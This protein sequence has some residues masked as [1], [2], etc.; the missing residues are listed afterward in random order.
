MVV[1]CT[2]GCLAG[3][4]WIS[5]ELDDEAKRCLPICLAFPPLAADPRLQG[6]R[7]TKAHPCLS[8]GPSFWL[9]SSEYGRIGR[10]SFGRQTHRDCYHAIQRPATF[11]DLT[12]PNIPIAHTYPLYAPISPY[13]R[14]QRHSS[15]RATQSLLLPSIDDH[16]LE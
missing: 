1:S 11:F 14:G 8:M 7:H 6:T 5:S 13:V 16:N 12:S 2:G 15:Y 3:T 10:G 4:G 9:W